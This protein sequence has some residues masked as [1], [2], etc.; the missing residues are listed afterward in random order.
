V[1]RDTFLEMDAGAEV[2]VVSGIYRGFIAVG[3]RS[4]KRFAVGKK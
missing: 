1:A 2:F 3:L 4:G